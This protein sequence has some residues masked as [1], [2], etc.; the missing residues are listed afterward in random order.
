ML[1]YS[2]WSEASETQKQGQKAMA[3][4]ENNMEV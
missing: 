2:S 4:E 1:I 3:E